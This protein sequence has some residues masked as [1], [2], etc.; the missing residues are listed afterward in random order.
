MSQKAIE[1]TREF[2]KHRYTYTGDEV[3][4]AYRDAG[5]VPDTEDAGRASRINWGNVMTAAEKCGI[6]ITVG[7]VRPRSTHSHIRST[8]L[9]K[10]L[11]FEGEPP[12][13]DIPKEIVMNLWQEACVHRSITVKEALWL[14]YTYGVENGQDTSSQ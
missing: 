6:H 3:F 14:A 9:R 5:H 7:R 12:I 4:E 2:A 8:C 13:V 11:V 1:F 10:S